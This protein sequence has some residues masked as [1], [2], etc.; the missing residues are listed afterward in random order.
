MISALVIT[1]DNSKVSFVFDKEELDIEVP[2]FWLIDLEGGGLMIFVFSSE[3]DLGFH[4]IPDVNEV[5]AVLH[6]GFHIELYINVKAWLAALTHVFVSAGE[7]ILFEIPHASSITCQLSWIGL[8][9][10]GVDKISF[11]I[12]VI[13]SIVSSA[14][15]QSTICWIFSV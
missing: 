2:D 13:F 3:G 15:G 14:S 8:E 5:L 7:K 6:L 1:V 9:L 10:L 12:L 11:T 4:F